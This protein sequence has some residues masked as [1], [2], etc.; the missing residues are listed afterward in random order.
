[1]RVL[2]LTN[3]FPPDVL[4]GY[5]LLAH[6]V[7]TRLRTRGHDGVVLTTGT[8]RVGDPRWVHRRLSLVRPFGAEP[9]LDRVGHA[10]LAPTQRRTVAAFLRE[11]GPFDACLVFSLRRLGLHAV[12]EIQAAGIPTVFA[13]N[14]DWLLSFQPGVGA[15]TARRRVSRWL[16]R[17]PL[18]ART[19]DGV[20]FDRVLFVS[21]ALRDGLLAA[22]APLPPGVVQHQG[23]EAE[24]FPARAHRPIG[25]APRLLFAGRLHPTKGCD[26]AIDAL[27][28]VRSSGLPATLS[29]AGAGHADEVER[30]HARARAA[31]V[32]EAVRWLGFVPRER[33]GAVYREHDVF[34][35]PSR[36]EEPLGLT[37]LEAM[38][39]GVPVVAMARGGAAELLEDGENALVVSCPEAM[40]RAVVRLASDAR[41]VARLW[42]GGAWTLR[43]RASLDAYVEAAERLLVAAAHVPAP[44]ATEEAAAPEARAS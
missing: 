43:H 1:M 10:L 9:S 26:V 32:E 23:V 38:S 30:L 31:G 22:G 12:R 16:E 44:G 3:L 4:G 36:W 19:W 41:L 24:R 29:I 39:S 42:S 14:D 40:A 15:S 21:R 17:G 34:L 20:R 6:D 33:L 11:H 7:A 8:P 2:L 37:Y 5:E 13:M 27:A 28:R 25:S 18:G 35:F